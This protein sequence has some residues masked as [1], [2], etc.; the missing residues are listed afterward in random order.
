MQKIQKARKE[1]DTLKLSAHIF[2]LSLDM[3]L[4]FQLIQSNISPMPSPDDS[5]I[6]NR[7][8]TSEHIFYLTL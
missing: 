4:W 6:L 2:S 1:A 5:R 8:P 3:F 7:C